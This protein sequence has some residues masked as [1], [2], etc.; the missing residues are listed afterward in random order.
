MPLPRHLLDDLQ[1]RRAQED[2]AA[3]RDKLLDYARTAVMCWAWCLVGLALIG[4][5][6]HT[7]DES[8]GRIAFLAG[9]GLGNAGMIFTLLGAYRRGEQRGDW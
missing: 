3:E 4:W 9:L 6:F 7:T 5:S 1:R 2:K 8:W